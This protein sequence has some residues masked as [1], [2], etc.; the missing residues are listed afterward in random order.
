M[1]KHLPGKGIIC[2]TVL[3]LFALGMS[4]QMSFTNAN[5]KLHSSTGTLGSNAN[6]RSTN[7][8]VVVDMNADGLD[9]ICRLSDAG[10]VTIEFQKP[11]GTFT[12]LN[13]GTFATSGPWSMAAGDVDKNGYKDVI[14]G[15]G[16][17]LKLM[18]I[19]GSGSMSVTTLPGSSF[20][21][22]NMNFMDVNNDGWIDIF[23]CD[24]NS[25][26]KLWLNNGSG[27]FPAEAANSVINFDIT[28]GQSSGTSNDDSGN[29]GSVWTDFDNDGDVDLYIA[30]CRQSVS[31]GT[32]PRRIDVLMR[33]DGGNNYSSQASTYGLGSGDQ[34]WTPSFGDIDNDGDFDLFL[35]KHNTTSQMYINNGS[36]TFTSG[37]TFAFGNMPMQ[38]QFE[39]MDNDGY[40]DL[41]ISGDNDYRVYH[42]NGNGTFSDITAGIT[43]MNSGSNFLSF[44]TGDLN[45]DGKIDIYT[46]YGTT[47]NNPSTNTDDI[48][49]MNATSNTN[50]Y[51][52]LVM[53][54]TNSNNDALGARA[55]IYGTWGVQTR[56]VRAGESYGTQ[57]S[58]A[59]HF[60]LGSATSID[61]IVVNWPSGA[62][63][64]IVGPAIDQFLSVGESNQC[65]LSN[66]TATPSGSTNLCAGGSVTLTA[67]SGGGYTYLW[68]TGATTPSITVTTAGSYAVQVTQSP[69]CMST[70]P[71]VDVTLNANETP[72]ITPSS[73]VLSFC[74]GNSVTITSS[75]AASYTWSSGENTQSILVTTSGTYSVTIAGACQN[76][77][78]TAI[79]V[80]V[81]PSPAAPTGSDVYIP[82]AQIVTVTATG[83]NDTWYD[84][85][86]G[87]NV[88]GAGNNYTT[89]GA[90]GDT[91]FY[92]TDANLYG[93][94]IG[95]V[96]PVYHAG[97]NYSGSNTINAY[98]I[99]N[100]LSPCTLKTVK[101]YT[102]TAGIRIIELRNSTGTVINSYTVNIPAD[103]SVVTLNF[104]LAVGN[105][106]RL[107]TNTAQNVVTLGFNSPQ[108]MRSNSGISYPY[109][110]AGKVTITGC[111]QGTNVF[112]YF[113][114]WKIEDPKVP[115]ENSPR[116]PIKVIVTSTTGQTKIASSNDFS[117]YPNPA[118]ATFSVRLNATFN[119]QTNIELR[120]VTGRLLS[121]QN[122]DGAAKNQ[123]FSFDASNVSKGVYFVNVVNKGQRSIQKLVI[124]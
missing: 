74:Q 124:Q 52:T 105:A 64:V 42:N 116:T 87:G 81:M 31:S 15:Y 65:T 53:A 70:S 110:L 77:T 89:T 49:W 38:S 39:D 50:H 35:A 27:S 57:N 32:D 99:F 123:L 118:S 10:V 76:W 112:Y 86:T 75:P 71:S 109:T 36:G 96:A 6:N 107:S 47:Y 8:I 103:T 78:S 14:A 122:T 90:V 108:L 56:E 72:T 26:A 93:G 51:I 30:K 7:G 114:D 63:N 9:D 88:I 100:V 11:G 13:C 84:A 24:D 111:D 3:S 61:S 80:T 85:L 40:V 92:V 23:A 67:P 59:L 4:A 91:T 115:C 29:Y 120:D 104:P 83:T 66:V 22:Q 58:A 119:G 117:V 1:K 69:G 106:Y 25:Y 102:N 98:D 16:S 62:H 73:N 60:G 94:A 121:S 113:Y 28:A 45:H 2:T 18:K 44:A 95:N 97:T 5:A 12:Y 43:N 19:N 37:A 17:T 55:F 82:S 21:V 101:V 48:Y 41:M 20:F 33:N 68:S 46:S 34:D 79:S 54:P